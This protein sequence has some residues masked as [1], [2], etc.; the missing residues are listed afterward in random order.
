VI[1][2]GDVK[3]LAEKII[4]LFENEELRQKLGQGGIE[5]VKQFSA[6]AVAQKW[7][8]IYKKVKQEHA[9]K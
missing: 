1:R 9:S 5:Y 7:E 2:V 8:D 3:T 4:M 6:A